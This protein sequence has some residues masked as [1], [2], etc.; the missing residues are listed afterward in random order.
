MFDSFEEWRETATEAMADYAALRRHIE[1]LE[2]ESARLLA[3]VVEA[4]EWPAGVPEPTRFDEFKVEHILQ[5]SFGEDLTGELAVANHTSIAAARYLVSEVTTVIDHLPQCWAKVISG[6]APLHQARRVGADTVGYVPLDAWAQVDDLISPCLGAVNASRLG[7]AVEAAITA[8]NPDGVR[9]RATDAPRHVWVGGDTRDRLTGWVSARLDRR[10]A[11]CLDSTVQM[12]AD[13]LA[14]DGDGSTVDE[15]RAKAL[16][17]LADPGAALQLVENTPCATGTTAFTP[18]TQVYVHVHAENL[19]DG[20]AVAR[21]EQ[22]GPLLVSQVAALTQASRVT[23]TPVIHVEA[24]ADPVDAYEIPDRIRRQVLAR[25]PHDVFPWSSTPSRHLDLDHTIGYQPGIPGQT[26][27]D[28][29]GPLSRKAH[30]IKTHAG[31]RL[32]QPTPGVF[33]WHTAAGQQA[34]VD[35]LGTHPINQDP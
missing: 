28:N 33:L 7:R 20:D 27:P 21:V 9:Q 8:T 32:D 24:T 3:R 16:G 19:G 26:R 14:V 31:W 1:Q 5:H 2:T 11:L 35:H 25:E 23:L 34:R 18:R 12:L 22:I 29:L 13:K 4:Y 10:D 30:R 6:R 17:L 15:R